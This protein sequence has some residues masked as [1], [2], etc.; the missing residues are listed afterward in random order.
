MHRFVPL[1][2][3][4]HLKSLH[5]LNRILSPHHDSSNQ[6]AE[7][8]HRLSEMAQDLVSSTSPVTN[9]STPANFDAKQSIFTI[10]R[11]LRNRIYEHL[12]PGELDIRV[13]HNRAS[14]LIGG[15]YH[16][17]EGTTI[18]NKRD[19]SAFLCFSATCT[20]IHDE[21]ADLY[22]NATE[23][24]IVIMNLKRDNAFWTD[25]SMCAPSKLP[26]WFPDTRRIEMEDIFCFK[27]DGGQS[28]CQLPDELCVLK[29]TC[30][31]PSTE[32]PWMVR[33]SWTAL[34]TYH[35]QSNKAELLAA[36]KDAAS[37]W[38]TTAVGSNTQLWNAGLDGDKLLEIQDEMADLHYL[39]LHNYLGLQIS[40][41]AQFGDMMGVLNPEESMI[42]YN[43]YLADVGGRICTWESMTG[44]NGGEL[45]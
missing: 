39:Q 40:L 38:I 36:T 1:S 2:C 24:T 44:K 31:R 15:R 12:L 43:H 26:R 28:S 41:Q 9:L 3:E 45:E 7:P 32:D 25:T 20:Q 33:S 29:V 19:W 13:V 17:V 10:P 42:Q 8:L 4:A 11:E 22:R 18:V 21:A 6:S 37:A 23:K 16:P 35:E 27:G 30:S 14:Q 5:H 34:H